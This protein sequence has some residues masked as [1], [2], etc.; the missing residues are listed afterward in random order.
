MN[1]EGC[2]LC[3][4]L[5]NI[6]WMN[7]PEGK[8][9]EKCEPDK[10][11]KIYDTIPEKCKSYKCA[12]NQAPNLNTDLRPDKCGIVF[13]K[14]TDKIFYGTLDTNFVMNDVID[15]QIK[16]F[17][18]KGFSVVLRHLYIPAPVIFNSENTTA[19]NIWKEL[20]ETWLH[21]RMQQI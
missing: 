2:T 9:C 14:A 15:K 12:Y 6:P 4:K 13:E 20:K 17:L 11:C 3:C 21:L 8:Y 10:G 19:E 16:S 5:F 1:C 18:E 7:S